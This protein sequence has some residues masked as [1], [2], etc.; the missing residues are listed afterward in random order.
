MVEDAQC[1]ITIS[2]LTESHMPSVTLRS[3]PVV[4]SN[5]AEGEFSD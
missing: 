4:Q 5:Y 3:I 1:H 2:Q